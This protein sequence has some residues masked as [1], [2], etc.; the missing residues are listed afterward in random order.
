MMYI[1][2]VEYY[3]AIKKN[4]IMPFAA[5][6]FPSGS[7]A[8]NLPVMQGSAGDAGLIPGSGKSPGEGSCNPFLYSCL[9]NPMDRGDW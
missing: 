4:E 7:V 3:S 1:Y 8:K 5:T 2:T 6:W 9:G